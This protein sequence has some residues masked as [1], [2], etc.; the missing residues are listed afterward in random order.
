LEALPRIDFVDD[1]E[2]TLFTA[3]IHRAYRPRLVKSPVIT[4]EQILAILPETTG[5]GYQLAEKI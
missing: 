4:E 5:A 2:G 1:R 3:T